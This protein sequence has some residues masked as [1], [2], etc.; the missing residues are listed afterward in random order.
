[1][2]LAAEHQ[3]NI[4]KPG[5]MSSGILT[6][7]GKKK[8]KKLKLIVVAAKIMTRLNGHQVAPASIN[9]GPFAL[10][11]GNDGSLMLASVA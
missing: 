10:S 2:A 1:M 8:K 7:T 5:L 4:N 9:S 6:A 3:D 11:A